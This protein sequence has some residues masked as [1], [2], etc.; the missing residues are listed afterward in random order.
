MAVIKLQKTV[1]ADT[2]KVFKALTEQ[3]YLEKW[4]A[5]EVI[6]VPKQDTYAAFA[7]GFDLN[8]KV[9]ILKLIPRQN[10]TWEFVSGSVGWDNSLI[11]FDLESIQGKTKVLFKHKGLD[12]NIEKLEKWK[13]SWSN[14][15]NKLKNFVQSEYMDKNPVETE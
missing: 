8:F 15:L 9:Y 10:I 2:G 5:P 12:N 6:T 7:F 14:Y 13:K 11:S 4:F 3:K 1:N